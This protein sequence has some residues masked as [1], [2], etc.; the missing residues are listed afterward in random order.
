MEINNPLETP[1]QR[2]WL[3]MDVTHPKIQTLATQVEA[4]CKRFIHQGAGAKQL[5]IQGDS[6]NGKTHAA[7]Q[8]YNW[9]RAVSMCAFETLGTWSRPPSSM[10]VAWPSVSDGFK[11]GEFG[12]VKDLCETDLTV[13]DDIGAESDRSQIA[14]D[15]L[16]QI[17]SQREGKRW[18]VIT[19][20]IQPELWGEKFDVRIADRLLR[21]ST[22]ID[23]DG[24]P[25]YA[26]LTFQR[27]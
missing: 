26:L 11:E 7:K 8:I 3:A 19:T 22:F 15:K 10:L 16:C 5:V 14:T 24:V 27:A 13:I 2:K 6:G 25:S 20:N 17:L 1:W 4:Y 21:D 9:S 23:L 12:I 18:T